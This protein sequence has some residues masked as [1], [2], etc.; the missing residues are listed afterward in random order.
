M[1]T[2]III[3]PANWNVHDTVS[4]TKASSKKIKC[5]KL[6]I[7]CVIL[8]ICSSCLA[9]ITLLSQDTVPWKPLSQ[10]LNLICA[11]YSWVLILRLQT[12]DI[13]V[14]VCNCKCVLYQCVCVCVRERNCAEEKTLVIHIAVSESIAVFQAGEWRISDLGQ[15]ME[16]FPA[17]FQPAFL[18]HGRLRWRPRCLS[19]CE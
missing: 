14:P 1:F 2:H 12:F 18:H 10:I 3:K 11:E 15:L 7:I 6:W 8:K 4:V 19:E 17:V 5:L 9:C 16:I 13:C